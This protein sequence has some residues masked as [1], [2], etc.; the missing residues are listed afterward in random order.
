MGLNI[1][2]STLGGIP[3]TRNGEGARGKKSCKTTNESD[4]DGGKKGGRK[5]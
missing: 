2:R 5:D 1:A 4:P 3:V